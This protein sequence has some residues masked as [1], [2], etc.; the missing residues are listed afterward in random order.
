M[1]RAKRD[2]SKGFYRLVW[3]EGRER[4]KRFDLVFTR[5]LDGDPNGLGINIDYEIERE[6]DPNDGL[7]NAI[8]KHKLTKAI[9]ISY[10]D[11][12]MPQ[13]FLKDKNEV[14]LYC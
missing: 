2:Y 10:D 9:W 11:Y 3:M 12:I 7:R 1:A 8:K 5:S 14:I 13:R 6:I 4:E